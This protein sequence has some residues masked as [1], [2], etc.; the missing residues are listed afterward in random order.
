MI[1]IMTKPSRNKLPKFKSHFLV[2]EGSFL[3]KVHCTDPNIKI[4]SNN[5]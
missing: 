4:I 1:F 3:M 5:K 2:L